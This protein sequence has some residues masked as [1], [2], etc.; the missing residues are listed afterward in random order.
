MTLLLILL[1]AVGNGSDNV[2]FAA[3]Y[4]TLDSTSYDISYQQVNIS[5][6]G[7]SVVTSRLYGWQQGDEY[8]LN[9]E[10]MSYMLIYAHA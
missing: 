9:C 7:D 10:W 8:W 2:Y 5:S 3:N 4:K 1:S 6:A